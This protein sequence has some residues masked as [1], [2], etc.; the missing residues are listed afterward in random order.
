LGHDPLDGLTRCLRTARCA[1]SIKTVLEPF[2]FPIADSK[3]VA[4]RETA[5]KAERETASPIGKPAS[6]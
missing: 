2:P 6:V 5:P 3:H 4:N 1:G